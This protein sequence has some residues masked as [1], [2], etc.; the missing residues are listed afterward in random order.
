MSNVIAH[1]LKEKKI[2]P[3]Q[4]VIFYF[5]FLESDGF[6]N[7]KH[8]RWNI[9]QVFQKLVVYAFMSMLC[10]IFPFFQANCNSHISL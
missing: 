3:A 2:S 6:L 7:D 8:L 5:K 4:A 10:D 1:L 9:P